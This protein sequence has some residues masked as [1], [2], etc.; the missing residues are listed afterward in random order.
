M[1][2]IIRIHWL[3]KVVVIHEKQEIDSQQPLQDF[4]TFNQV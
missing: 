2:I 3:T 4:L 1:I